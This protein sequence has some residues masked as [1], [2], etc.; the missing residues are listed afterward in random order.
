[1]LAAHTSAHLPLMP[2]SMCLLLLLLESF[3]EGCS[4]P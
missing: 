3:V 1:L 4:L 2:R